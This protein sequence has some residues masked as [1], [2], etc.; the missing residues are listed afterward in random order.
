MKIT[1]IKL[2]TIF[3]SAMVVMVVSGGCSITIERFP[4]F[5]T[6]SGQ[7]L[8]PTTTSSPVNTTWSVPSQT[9]GADFTN[10][11]DAVEKIRPS[12][13]SVETSTGS[14]SG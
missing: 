7:A 4:G 9:P 10:W 6:T 1:R 13:V 14:G 12:V 5:T 8:T 3:C 11:A 2:F